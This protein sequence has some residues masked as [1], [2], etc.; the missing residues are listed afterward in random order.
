[1]II[2]RV[3]DALKNGFRYLVVDPEGTV[4]LARE[5]DALQVPQQGNEL[6]PCHVQVM[7]LQR[8]DEI[9]TRLVGADPKRRW[10]LKDMAQ[11]AGRSEVTINNWIVSGI[12]PPETPEGRRQGHGKPRLF[13][14]GDLLRAAIARSLSRRDQGKEVLTRALACVAAGVPMQKPPPRKQRAQQAARN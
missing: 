9:L 6:R 13:T 4:C 2:D 5:S 8:Y 11:I 14:W 7:D 3:K 12:L 1:M 10:Y